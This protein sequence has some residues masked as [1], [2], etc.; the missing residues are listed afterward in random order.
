MELNLR[1]SQRQHE[2][3]RA[4]WSMYFPR[5]RGDGLDPEDLMSR[6]QAL[7]SL[8]ELLPEMRKEGDRS[9]LVLTATALWN[10]LDVYRIG[11]PPKEFSELLRAVLALDVSR[12]RELRAQPAHNV[13][14]P[15]PE[16]QSLDEE[17]YALFGAS[18]LVSDSSFEV[19]R[20]KK[21]VPK[22]KKS[23]VPEDQK[24][25]TFR[26]RASLELCVNR[27]FERLTVLS[28]PLQW[29]GLCPVIWAHMEE[30]GDGLEGRL[31]LPGIAQ[32]INVSFESVG[33]PE[34]DA[35]QIEAELKMKAPPVIE[36]GYVK[37]RMEPERGRPG[38]TRITHEREVTFFSELHRYE[39]PTLA[40]WTKSEIACLALR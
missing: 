14:P 17:L 24:S 21:A 4:A 28:D 9:E 1:E 27:D 25:E 10:L 3:H 39:V 13:F 32:D 38:W 6:T 22:S 37:F 18:A 23:S 11:D 2:V 8:R 20:N 16:D 29:P 30:Q 5:R 19:R 33:E 12:A 15:F 31:R 35:T 7:R 34:S 26:A 36:S 40:Y